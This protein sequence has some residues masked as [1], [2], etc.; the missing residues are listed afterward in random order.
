MA[1]N[2][3]PVKWAQ[4]ADSI[5]LTLDL[6]DVKDE[7]LKLTKDML[8][9]SGTSNDKKYALEL[10]FL[11][12]VNSE[13]STWKVLPRSIQM[14]IMKEAEDDVF[15]ERLLKDKS[16]EK[17]NVKIDWNKFVDEDEEEGGEGFDMSALDGGS[18]FG[19]GGMPGMG[20]MGGGM[21]GGGMPPGMEGIMGAGGM[22][23]I[24]GG[25]DYDD[26]DDDAEADS[27]DEGLP[28]LEDDDE[29]QQD[30]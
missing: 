5:Y 6:P 20:G 30:A 3:A 10:E 2:T 12:N 1:V 18:Q 21:G 17:T 9:F 23:G 16:L 22:G 8:S 29:P 7:Q 19:G 24:G 4:R 25:E 13:K 14:H 26:E 28:D 15:W 11:H 27:D